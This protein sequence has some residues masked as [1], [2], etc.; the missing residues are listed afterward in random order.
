[1]TLPQPL[2]FTVVTDAWGHPHSVSED[3]VDTPTHLIPL[4]TALARRTDAESPSAPAK[5]KKLVWVTATGSWKTRVKKARFYL[6]NAAWVPQ[7]AAQQ[8]YSLFIVVCNLRRY[9]RLQGPFTTTLIQEHYTP[10][11]VSKVPGFRP[12]LDKEILEKYRLAGKRG[13]YPTLGVSDPR[14]KKKVEKQALHKA[15][16]SFL[17]KHVKPG[18]SCTP[19]ELLAAFKAIH[20]G[21]TVNPN[22]FGRAVVA[23]TGIKSTTP[24]GKRTYRGIHLSE[25]AMGLTTALVDTKKAV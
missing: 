8:S 19:Q 16:R 25:T 4:D 2:F 13:V 12:W 15:V 10:R 20:G 3:R 9:F 23:F 1:M 6:Q 18:G 11:L 17:K 24:F 22:A 7:D 14:A 21:V 5:G